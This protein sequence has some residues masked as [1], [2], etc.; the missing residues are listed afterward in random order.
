MQMDVMQDEVCESNRGDSLRWSAGVDPSR[1]HVAQWRAMN[2]AHCRIEYVLTM[3][4][5]ELGLSLVEFSVLDILEEQVEGHLRMQDVALVAAL[6]TG[7]TTRLVSRLEDRGLLK[8]YLCETDRR[9]IFTELTPAGLALLQQARSVHD[10]ALSRAFADPA[11]VKAIT[12]TALAITH[13]VATA[14]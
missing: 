10:S 5:G 8:R 11:N 13:S 4:V 6:T 1:S 14:T 7:A 2:S 9:G 12:D 3:A